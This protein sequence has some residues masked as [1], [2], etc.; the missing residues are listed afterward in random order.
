MARAR[1]FLLLLL[2]VLLLLFLLDEDCLL[3]F[4][5]R[6][7]LLFFDFREDIETEESRDIEE[8]Y[9]ARHQNGR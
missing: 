2:F 4:E 5:R 7:D 8:A 9:L 1:C 6:D 3:R